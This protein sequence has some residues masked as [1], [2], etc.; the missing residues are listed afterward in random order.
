MRGRFFPFLFGALLA[1][2]AGHT[3]AALELPRVIIDTAYQKPARIVRVA[4]GGD[5]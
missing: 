4:A 2:T 5:L 1:L 3:H